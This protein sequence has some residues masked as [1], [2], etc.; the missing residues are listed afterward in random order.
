MKETSL[1]LKPEPAFDLWLDRLITGGILVF[2]AFLPFHLVIKKLVPDPVGTYWKEGLLL[3]LVLLWAVRCLRS[4]KLLLS[5][6]PLDLPVLLYAGMILLRLVLDRSGSVGLWGAYISILYLPLFWLVPL[7][8]RR[9]PGLV[10]GLLLGLTAVGALIS[11]GA[12]LEFLVDKPLWPS[13]ELTMRQGYPDMYVYGTH[14]RRVYFVFDS[15]TTLANTLAIILPLALLSIF[16]V[17]KLWA[18]LAAA[19][20]AVLIFTAIILTFSRGIW[21][22]VALAAFVVVILKLITD[23]KWK[24]L[25]RAGL[26]A[27]TALLILGLVW[28][29]TP[30]SK[31]NVDQYSVEL[32]PA[33]YQQIP[34]GDQVVSLRDITPQEGEPEKQV[35]TVFDPIEQRDDTREVIYTHPKADA[36]NQ[37]IYTLTV[38]ENGLLRVSIALSPEVWNSEKGDGVN[39]KIFVQEKG[40]AEGQFIFIRY[41][42]PKANPSDRR[43]RNYAVDLSAWSGKEVNLS[44]IAEAGP[45][46]DYGYDW[47]GWADLDLGSAA[48]GYVAANWP[49]PQSPVAEH[50]T[51]ITDWTQDE[52]NRDRLAAWNQGLAAWK[53]NPIW[54]NGLGTTG[55]AALRTRPET[56]FVTES[57]VLKSLVELG[58][59]GLLIWAFLWFSI[60]R[61]AWKVFRAAGSDWEKFLALS[62]IGSLLVVFIDGLVYQN[63]EVKQVNALFWALTGLLAFLWVKPA[64]ADALP[65]VPEV[66]QVEPELVAGAEETPQAA[67]DSEA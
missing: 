3:V 9:Y 12:I 57:Q 35:W 61:T 56:A 31:S 18:R 46:G 50:L 62:L 63:L 43:W 2:L 36:P 8:L 59:P 4:R 27:V 5:G 40:A 32:L 23:H 37:V 53:L 11:L 47:A 65:S 24:F 64:V 58:I 52:S 33:A 14:L 20:A 29:T 55:A 22:A 39:F 34:L 1:N 60:A 26:A 67:A 28:V 49:E 25:I 19:A 45:A 38:P 44:L 21:V 51:S 13:V 66:P 16:Q 54:G 7:A 6:T 48:E 17:R 41:I 10:K 30:T 42:N 15:P